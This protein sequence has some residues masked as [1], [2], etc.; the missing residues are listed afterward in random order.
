MPPPWHFAQTPNAGNS[1]EELYAFLCNLVLA[2]P[3]GA[4]GKY[5][6]A[7]VPWVFVFP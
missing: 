4:A 5:S 2:V 3:Q 1:H 6:T 7:K